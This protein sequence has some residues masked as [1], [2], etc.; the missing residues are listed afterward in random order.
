MSNIPDDYTA[1]R[2][3]FIVMLETFKSMSVEHLDPVTTF[4][5]S[6]EPILPWT[7]PAHFFP[8]QDGLKA[9]DFENNEID[10]MLL[11]NVFEV[12]PT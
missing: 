8:R 12:L 5:N 10:N 3:S 4:P 2:E 1:T 9:Q 7:R 6:V 11:T